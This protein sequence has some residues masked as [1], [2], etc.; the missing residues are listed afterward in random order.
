[1]RVLLLVETLSVGGLPNYVLDL[2]RALRHAGDTV[3]LAHLGAEVPGH[4]DV[5]DVELLAARPR[6]EASDPLA[7]LLRNWQPDIVHVHLCSEP[8]ALQTLLAAGIPTVRSY[9]D[10]TSICL[11][12][13]RRRFPGDRCQRAL[14]L[15]CAFFGCLIGP[16]VA[17][18]RFVS[19][20]DLPAKLNERGIY[21]SFSASIVGS[22]HMRRV[23]LKNGFA[24]QRLNMVPYFSRFHA[25]AEGLAA[26]PEKPAGRAG[27]DRPFHMLFSGQAVAG[28]GLRVLVQALAGVHGQWRLVAVTSGPELAGVQALAIQL[29]LQD[30]IT[31][32]GWL[33]Q[34]ALA[35]H[36][37]HADLL[38]LPSVWDDPGPL[39]GIEAMSF[40]TPVVAFPVGGI[41]D[42]VIDQQTGWLAET[43]S[44]P[45]LS[46]ALQRAMRDPDLII[47][48]GRAS[49]ALIAARHTRAAH[50]DAVRRIYQRVAHPLPSSVVTQECT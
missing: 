32:V 48:R 24:D 26:M 30:R 3:A 14:G 45:A 12:R 20:A 6:S 44:V 41:P 34:E 8:H 21:Q 25:Q 49:R 13:G 39:V 28:K 18:G 17:D 36:Y 40:E 10:Y 35:G 2:A 38:V 11:R 1:M 19:L 43:V 9:H 5:A 15:S 29:G 47:E 50:V 23:L 33:P 16:P 46:A 7:V 4:L 37:R 27:V 22:E 42:Y 31:F